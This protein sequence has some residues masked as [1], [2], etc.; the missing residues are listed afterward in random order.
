MT[1]P[2]TSMRRPSRP[3]D[4]YRT[5]QARAPGGAPSSFSERISPPG[6]GSSRRGV[7]SDS[8]PASPRSERE[9]EAVGPR[10]EAGAAGRERHASAKD[11][12]AA[13]T[14]HDGAQSNAPVAPEN[15]P[16]LS[17]A[18]TATGERYNP[19]AQSRPSP[20]SSTPGRASR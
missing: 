15:V 2:E 4:E 3:V 5:F 16:R 1:T 8:A 13:E 9:V 12:R 7:A 19:L 6:G 17:P 18:A 20:T 14:S 11:Q 10:A